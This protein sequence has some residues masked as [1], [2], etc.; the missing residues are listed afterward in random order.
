MLFSDIV[1]CG[2]EH[3]QTIASRYFVACD[4]EQSLNKMIE[5]NLSIF[6]T[7]KLHISSSLNFPFDVVPLAE[8]RVPIVQDLLVLV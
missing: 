2:L 4:N 6:D 8:V 3:E 5:I 1:S 7:S